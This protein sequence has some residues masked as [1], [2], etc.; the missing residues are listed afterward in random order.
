MVDKTSKSICLISSLPLLSLWPLKHF[1]RL[2]L[3]L[4]GPWNA[5]GRVL[6]FGHCYYILRRYMLF[7]ERR[8]CSICQIVLLYFCTHR[9]CT[10]CGPASSSILLCRD[11][12]LQFEFEVYLYNMKSGLCCTS[13]WIHPSLDAR[14]KFP[15]PKL[16]S[17]TTAHSKILLCSCIILL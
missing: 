7:E 2:R 9:G 4:D 16:Q 3:D 14:N 6:A 5:C 10:E 11:I 12:T 15:C 17:T 13:F 8:D 1:A